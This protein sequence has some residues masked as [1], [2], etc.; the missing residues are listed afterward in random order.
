MYDESFDLVVLDVYDRDEEVVKELYIQD[1]EVR[2][3][4]RTKGLVKAI[5]GAEVDKF[6]WEWLYD[7]LEG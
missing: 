7:G 6:V 5:W 3:I 2:Y 1:L 4:A